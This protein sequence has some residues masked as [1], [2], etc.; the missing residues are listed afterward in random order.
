[1]KKLL[2]ISL[3]L[4]LALSVGL[5][6]CGGEGEGE[7]PAA[8]KVGLVRDLNGVLSAFDCGYG[9]TVYRW[10][11]N[12]TNTAGGIFMS[13][14]N[15]TLPLEVIVR[16]FD[17]LNWGTLT[18][19]TNGLLYSDKVDFV[20]GAPGTDTIYTQGPICNAAGKLLITLEGGASNMIWDSPTYLDVWPYVWVSLSF[21][22]WYEI[23]V[24]HDVLDEAVTGRDPI[25]WVSHIGE[26]G[27]THGQEYL[28][29]TKNQFGLNNTIDGGETEYFP[30]DLPGAAAAVIAAAKAALGNSSNPNYDVACFFTYPWW[31]FNLIGAILADTTFNPPAIIFGPGGN[32]GDIPAAFGPMA[33]GLMGFTMANEN[34]VPNV[35]T[36]T[37]SMATMYSQLGTQLELDWASGSLPACDKPAY[38]SN[39][40]QCV[41]YWGMPCYAAALDMWKQAVQ[42]VGTLEAGY[43]AAVRNKLASYNSTNPAS[44]V[45]GNTWYEVFSQNVSS[46]NYRLGGGVLS[47]KCHTGEIGQWQSGVLETVGYTGITSVIPNYDTTASFKLMTDQWAWLP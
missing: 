38:V 23:P 3:A 27:A 41:D 40:S 17:P 14:Y 39:G 33:E 28:Q 6:G 37:M 11:A 1:V 9:G 30:A 12:K 47:Y 8:I 7:V 25:A 45:L 29:E 35:G 36:P 43:S 15:A 46:A 4:V 31:V 19:E 42:A 10:F 24:L 18:T 26:A 20:W 32:T 13:A 2:F 21:A 44:T 5:V 34:T 16:D 22:N